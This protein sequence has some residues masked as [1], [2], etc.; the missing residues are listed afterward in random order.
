MSPD[1][2]FNYVLGALTLAGFLTTYLVYINMFLNTPQLRQFDDMLRDT[3]NVYDDAITE[4][5]LPAEMSMKARSR[6]RDFQSQG[7]DFRAMTQSPFQILLT[8]FR[9][10]QYKKLKYLSDSLSLLHTELV[11]TSQEE[12]A[13]R[14]AADTVQSENAPA[15][16]AN[17]YAESEDIPRSGYEDDIGGHAGNPFAISAIVPNKTSPVCHSTFCACW[18]LQRFMCSPQEPC[19]SRLGGAP[20]SCVESQGKP[21]R[22]LSSMPLD[23]LSRS[24]TL[25]AEP[26]PKPASAAS[27]PTARVWER[28]TP[29][30]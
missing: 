10:G 26:L 19:L 20:P 25:V 23:I 17:V 8:M 7:D 5:L 9:R 21:M 22:S 18:L 12:R 4:G 2:V 11:T 6:I 15:L 14:Q 13:R 27:G 30:G 16:N 1:S 29:R 3:K 24:S 28:Q